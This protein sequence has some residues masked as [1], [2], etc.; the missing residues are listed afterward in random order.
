[1]P[2]IPTAEID[3]SLLNILFEE[4]D[5]WLKIQDGRLTTEPIPKA[6]VDST[7]WPGSFS[8]IVRHRL[9]NG[10]HVATTHRIIALDGTI[11]HQDAKDILL[12]GMRL[13]RR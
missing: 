12:Q 3:L 1:M 7:H 8:Q 9:P 11:D 4:F 2:R 10:K 5:L 13:W 6:T